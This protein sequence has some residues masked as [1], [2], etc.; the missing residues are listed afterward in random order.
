MPKIKLEPAEITVKTSWDQRVTR[1]ITVHNAGE[2]TLVLGGVESGVDWIR[3]P[4]DMPTSIEARSSAEILLTFV[5]GQLQEIS[6]TAAD[7]SSTAHM[8]LDTLATAKAVFAACDVDE[9]GELDMGEMVARYGKQAGHMLKEFDLDLDGTISMDELI[10]VLEDKHAEDAV[11]TAK[12]LQFLAAPPR[13]EAI[14]AADAAPPIDRS[15]FS[16]S[17][18]I[19]ESKSTLGT[20]EPE[21][22]RPSLVVPVLLKSTETGN[23]N[24]MLIVNS[25]DPVGMTPIPIMMR[26][27]APCIRLGNDHA[28]VQLDNEDDSRFIFEIHNDGDADLHIQRIVPS[29]PEAL[30]VEQTTV[31]P[32]VV[33]PYSDPTKIIVRVVRGS[34]KNLRGL[35]LTVMSDDP[36]NTEKTVQVELTALAPQ[37]RLDPLRITTTIPKEQQRVEVVKIANAG[38][39]PLKVLSIEPDAGCA[40]WISVTSEVPFTVE[41]NGAIHDVALSISTQAPPNGRGVI[42]V[43][44]SDMTNPDIQ[45][46]VQVREPKVEVSRAAVFCTSWAELMCCKKH[47]A[48]ELVQVHNEGAAATVRSITSDAPWLEPHFITAGLANFPWRLTNIAPLELM[49]KIKA[50]GADGVRGR[51][52]HHAVIRIESDDPRGAPPGVKEIHVT[53]RIRSCLPLWLTRFCAATPEIHC[54]QDRAMTGCSAFFG[55]KY[56]RLPETLQAEARSGE[57]ATVSL[58]LNN[59]GAADLTVDRID[60]D[61]PEWATLHLEERGAF[62]WVFKGLA[63]GADGLRQPRA[64]QLFTLVMKKTALGRANT[65]INIRS[66]DPRRPAVSVPV[67]LDVVSANKDAEAKRIALLKLK[68]L[69]LSRAYTPWL[70]NARERLRKFGPV[71]SRGGARAAAESAAAA[72]EAAVVAHQLPQQ[73]EPEL[74]PEPELELPPF[75][76]VIELPPP[77]EPPE[78]ETEQEP[79]DLGAVA[80]LAVGPMATARAVAA[81]PEQ[82]Q[83]APSWLDRDPIEQ[84][85]SAPAAEESN[86]VPLNNFK[87]G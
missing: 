81:E 45:I 26:V 74:W 71:V 75:A 80:G 20:A 24:G 22:P 15:A 21:E 82:E 70:A 4:G 78:P 37:I 73:P 48:S 38:Q 2:H 9:S 25:N 79:S 32:L 14:S 16:S 68:N 18:S 39:A 43:R 86:G 23:F 60:V 72:A 10:R 85:P 8:D 35:F 51:G 17:Q 6:A 83:A 61:N 42:H 3:L 40:D 31:Y 52:D 44:S 34:I 53:V 33:Q 56:Q 41:P 66:S 69:R 1:A 49:L 29:D 87:F 55:Q 62:P 12:W 11:S 67:V 5:P 36:K 57:E 84:V 77:P 63:K 54:Q 13:A 76:D 46:P 27:T 64:P 65:N 58:W 28:R 50:S 7:T 59:N 30:Q 47:L 19:P